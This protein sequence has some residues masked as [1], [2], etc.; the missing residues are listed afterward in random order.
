MLKG[1]KGETDGK[2]ITVGDFNTPLTSVDHSRQ[3]INKATKIPNETIK[4]RVS[5]YFQDNTI[6]K[7]EYTFFSRYALGTVSRTGCIPGHK[8]NLNK[9]KSIELISSVWPQW[10]K[11]R[12]KPQPEKEWEKKIT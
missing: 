11:T 7:W 3:K 9:F 6:K 5:W 12:N 10:H 8:T 4:V 1:I 2:T